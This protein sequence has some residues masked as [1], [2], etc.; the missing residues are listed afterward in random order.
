M[1]TVNH[2]LLKMFIDVIPNFDG[3]HPLLNYFIDACDG[4]INNYGNCESEMQNKFLIRAIKN[5]L[6][7]QV[8]INIST[9]LENDT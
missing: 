2:Q 3:T 9:R 6:K 4:L 1:S 8:Q 7:G 5:K